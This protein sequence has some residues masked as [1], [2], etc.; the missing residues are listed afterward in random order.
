MVWN[1][2]VNDSRHYAVDEAFAYTRRITYGHYE[3]F[4]V[5]SWCIP[6]RLRQHVSN[7]YAFARGAD[8]FA[9]EDAYAGERMERLQEWRTM[10]HACALSAH[11]PEDN[12]PCTHPVFIALRESIRDQQLPVQLLNDLITAFMLDV[13][14]TR[15]SSFGEVMHYCRYS[16]NPVGRLMLHLFGY[17]NER[18]MTLSDHICSALQQA[19]FWQDVSRDL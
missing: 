13:S 3:N 2:I 18:W 16:A 10:L 11:R 12:A 19:N 1:G 6:Q 14:K 4:P 8:D 9:D 15:Y 17:V 7:I 5:A